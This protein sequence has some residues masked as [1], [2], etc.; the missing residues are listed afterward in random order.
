MLSI[1]TWYIMNQH[2]LV[3]AEFVLS[4][5]AGILFPNQMMQLEMAYGG[6]GM[7][8]LANPYGTIAVAGFRAGT[9]T[10]FIINE[11]RMRAYNTTL[12]ENLLEFTGDVGVWGPRAVDA[13]ERLKKNMESAGVISPSMN[14]M[15][16]GHH[17][18]PTDAIKVAEKKGNLEIKSLAISAI[19]LLEKNGI[20][21]EHPANG[22]ILRGGTNYGLGFPH[23]ATGVADLHTGE[24]IRYVAQKII[25][26]GQNGG[27][28]AEIIA[29]LQ[30]IGVE[31]LE[32]RIFLPAQ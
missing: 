2:R 14:G 9:R 20:G 1:G 22:V 16:I 27:T 24:Y 23:G 13:A 17:I 32:S 18:M 3:G 7:P 12:L 26:A 19:R 10:G 25:N 8:S 30:E 29:T 15:T 4:F 5:G 21:P 6:Q 31:L 28:D 11:A